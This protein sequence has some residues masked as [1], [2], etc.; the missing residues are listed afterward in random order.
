MPGTLC[1]LAV[2]SLAAALCVAPGTAGAADAPGPV[3]VRLNFQPPKDWTETKRTTERP[4]LWRDW[5]FRD[6]TVVHSI[7]MSVTREDRPAAAYGEAAAASLKSAAGV[8]EVTSGPSTT[9]GDV[10]AYA[11]AYRSDRT[12]GHPL[13]IRHLLVDVAG[14]VGDV[15]YAHPPDVADR[16]DA[17]DA[18]S[19]FCDQQIYAI[20]PPAGWKSLGMFSPGNAG[21]GMFTSPDA[22]STL[23]GLAVAM[24]ARTGALFLTSNQSKK[25]STLISEGDETCGAQRIHRTHWR[26]ASDKGVKL[27]EMVAAYHHGV[28]YLYTY[29]RPES[30]PADPE[31]LRAL[32]SFCDAG[33]AL[34]TPAPS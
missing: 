29:T 20:R 22:N 21:I 17:L 10:P 5:L 13:M 24:P 18:M 28:S 8:S 30:S 11:Y 26:N 25:G 15:S 12:P 9:C 16:T 7:V 4:G 1:R 23:I 33:A 3:S 2:L 31:A 32:T 14:L 27:D 34:A 19:T 6:G